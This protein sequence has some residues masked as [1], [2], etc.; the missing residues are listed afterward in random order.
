MNKKE[1]RS[2]YLA[3]RRALTSV[4]VADKSERITTQLFQSFNFEPINCVH[5]FLP[6]TKNNEINTLPLIKTLWKKGIDVVIPISN[7]ET[8]EM[9]CASFT[10]H[11]KT[12]LKKGIPEPLDPNLVS[13][14]KISIIISPLAIFDTKGFRIGYGGGFYD[15][16]IAKLSTKPTVIGL[17]FFEPIPTIQPNQYDLPLDFC[18]TPLSYFYF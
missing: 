13:P 16:F 1:L 14:D 6:I 10:P 8:N 7:F 17:S 15:R 18:I 2:S 5:C 3:K 9:E 12:V 11:T 4:E